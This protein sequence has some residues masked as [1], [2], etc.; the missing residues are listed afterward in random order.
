[1]ATYTVKK[2]DT[3]SDIAKQY[4]TTYQELAKA[5][6]ISN[7]NLI[8][9]GQTLNIGG[10]ETQPQQSA[11][12]TETTAPTPSTQQ[13]SYEDFNVSDS[14]AAADQKRQDVSAQKP[15]D[16]TYGAYEKSDIVKQAEA[17]LQQQLANNPG[18]Y[19]SQWQTQLDDTLNKILNRE[20][21]SYDLNGDALYQ[22]Y[23]DQFATQGK[24]ASMD[25][26]GQAQAMTGGYGNSYAQSV[27]QQAYQGYLQQLNEVVPELYQLAL[28][29]YNR[30][31]ED[32]YNQYGLYADRDSQ[33]YGRY[34]DQV[35]DY[36]TELNRLTEDSRYQGEQ[37]YGKY[38]DAYNMAYGQHRDQVSDWQTEQNRADNDYW[39]QY[40]RD[41]GQ[42]SDNR[43]MAYDNFWN[44]QNMSY[45]QGR[46]K[47]S[48]EQWQAEFDEAKRQYD[49][50]YELAA[51][52]KTGG[53]DTGD[54]EDDNYKTAPED[55]D[56]TDDVTYTQNGSLTKGKVMTLQ[57][58]L[59]VTAD[60]L[61]GPETQKAANGM[62]ADEAYNYYVLGKGKPN[63]NAGNGG[64]TGST[65]S[66]AAAYLKE[67]GLSAGGL[68]TQSEWQRHKNKNNSAGGEH[69][70]NT[71]QE[72]LDVYI[73]GM[74]NKK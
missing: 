13:W 41:Y 72:Y 44:E 33:D 58:I 54:T 24:L 68:M 32:L 18:A 48:D 35:S 36:Y 67:K 46:D 47:V 23:K 50:Q 28:D 66:E 49:Q 4:G 2:G 20:K 60:G 31:G 37:D 14:T 70:A 56:P 21:F 11:S 3:L 1:M 62:S 45:Q 43:N 5:N 30:E 69:E 19:Q 71:Y 55:T 34:R 39:N 7:P 27:G 65:Y 61:Y 26:M 52:K 42:Y 51:G 25:T 38:M 15:G 16:F 22:Q 53:T 63:D 9:V 6:G 59:G 8:R 17:L 73:Y 12:T 64:F 29:Q 74:T 10:N 40:D 57:R